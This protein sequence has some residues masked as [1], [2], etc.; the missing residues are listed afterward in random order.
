LPY[1]TVSSTSYDV[2]FSHNTFVIVKKRLRDDISYPRLNL[3]VGYSKGNKIITVE[4]Y[5]NREI[6]FYNHISMQMCFLLLFIFNSFTK[7][8]PGGKMDAL[9]LLY[10]AKI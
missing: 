3:T 5:D 9:A 8:M 6:L 7:E 2:L 1:P 4:F 10:F